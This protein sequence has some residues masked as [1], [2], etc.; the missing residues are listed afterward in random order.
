[1]AVAED[2]LVDV[3]GHMPEPWFRQQFPV[4]AVAYGQVHGIAAVAPL[5]H[6]VLVTVDQDRA[7][8]GRRSG[9]VHGVE[10]AL[11]GTRRRSELEAFPEPVLV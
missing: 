3:A 2:H 5:R 8:S 7:W 4:E 9:E 10:D 6:L 1:M 11:R